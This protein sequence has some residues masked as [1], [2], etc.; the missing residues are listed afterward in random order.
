[1]RTPRCNLTGVL[2][3]LAHHAKRRAYRAC[4][5][6]DMRLIRLRRHLRRIRCRCP[7]SLLRLIA[8]GLRIGARYVPILSDLAAGSQGVSLHG[9]RNDRAWCPLSLRPGTSEKIGRA[10]AATAGP[11]AWTG[12]SSPPAARSLVPPSDQAG[13]PAKQGGAEVSYR[14]GGTTGAGKRSL[15][16]ALRSSGD[17]AAN[18]LDAAWQAG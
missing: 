9:R 12:T 16:Q 13:C 6:G 3:P 15:S 2:A 7:A 10:Q 8:G 18:G 17:V 11:P 1:L 5:T 14:D 4:A